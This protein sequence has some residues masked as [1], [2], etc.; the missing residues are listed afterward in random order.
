MSENER[1]AREILASTRTRIAPEIDQDLIDRIYEIE[2][3]HQFSIE[4]T[5]AKD[6]VNELINE[7]IRN[8]SDSN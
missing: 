3:K 8:P 4:Q 1:I 7:F 2:V 5:V 6:L